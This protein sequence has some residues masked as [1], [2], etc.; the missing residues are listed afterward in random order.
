MVYFSMIKSSRFPA[1]KST[2][3]VLPEIVMKSRDAVNSFSQES[4]DDKVKL[5]R[6]DKAIIKLSSWKIFVQCILMTPSFI[7]PFYFGVHYLGECPIQPLINTYLIVHACLNLVNILCLFMSF[8]TAKLITRSIDP[9]S[10]LRSLFISSL[11]GQLI[12]FLLSFAWLIVGQVWV[13]GSQANGF[14][15]ADSTQTATYCRSAVFWNAF[16]SIV[17]TYAIWLILILVIIGRFIFKRWKIQRKRT[18]RYDEY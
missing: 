3:P 18:P 5:D 17:V 8:L 15:S 12:V 4:P 2:P 1:E 10:C 14:Q 6:L 7:A 11:I 16:A 9:S 13:F